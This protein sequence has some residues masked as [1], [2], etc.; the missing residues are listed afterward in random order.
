M[1]NIILYIMV[2]FSIIAGMDRLFGNKLGLG[3]KFEEAFDSMGGMALSMIGIIGMAPVI[4]GLL[5]P[6]FLFLSKISGADPSIF[7]SSILAVDL[8]GYISSMELAQSQEIAEFAG[9]ILGSTMGA[10]ISFTIPISI[11]LISKEDFPYFAK[12][13]LAG[14]MTVPIGMLVGGIAMGI[15]LN[16]ILINL[17][18]VIILSLLIG[19]GLY[20]NPDRT[21]SIFNILGKLI[22]IIST[23]GLLISILDF[24]LGIKLLS[25][26]IGFEE[27]II[28][29]GKVIVVVSGAYPLFHFISN[30]FGKPID[31]MAKKLG[32]N[33]YSALGIITSLAHNVPTMGFYNDMDEKGKVLNAAFM[34]SGAFSLGGQLGYISSISKDMITPFLLA[35]LSAG[36]ASI[37]LANLIIKIGEKDR[38][39]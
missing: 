3:E 39:K 7:I 20:K 16:I 38:G 5:E 33:Q 8:G 27:G 18:P 6:T 37:F 17:I 14:I 29:V 36:F 31:N 1:G 9:L 2:M 22:I 19:L 15:H 32:V 21:L 30:K 10:T 11:N 25:N 35:K 4:S 28:T 34:V 23:I 12:G 13:I 26:M 24:V